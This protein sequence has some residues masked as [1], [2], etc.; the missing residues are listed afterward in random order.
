MPYVT[1]THAI[2]CYMEN[3][4][5][6]SKAAKTIFQKVDNLQEQIFIPCIVFFE[7]L[8]LTEKKNI[9]VDFNRFISLLSTSKN[10]RVEPLCLPIIRKCVE[11]PRE[12]VKDPWDR[13]I[14]ATS[15]H[16]DY[17][18]ISRDTSLRN[19]SLTGLKLIW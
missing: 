5:K 10:Y 8:Y 2:V 14:V 16:L 18:L 7:L 4:P 11:I 12:L 1:D 13:L 19:I 3:D 6:L 9:K 17:P 15:I